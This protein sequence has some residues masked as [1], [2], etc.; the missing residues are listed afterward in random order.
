MMDPQSEPD[1]NHWLHRLTALQW[2]AAADKELAL[3]QQALEAGNHKKG[4]VHARRGAGMGMNAVLC[5]MEQPDWGRSYMEHL[6]AGKNRLGVPEAVGAACRA[7]VE[8]GLAGGGLLRIGGGADAGPLNAARE[9]VAWCTAQTRL[10][11]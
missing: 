9:V 10:D 11:A 1:P 2:L 6:Q 4:L 8:E 5:R 7:L 3:A